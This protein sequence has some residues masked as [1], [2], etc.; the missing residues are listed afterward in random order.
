M[1]VK[2]LSKA[3][4]KQLYSLCMRESGKMR[5][6]LRTMPDAEVYMITNDEGQVYCWSIIFPQNDKHKLYI[7]T[8][9]RERRRGYAT[10]LIEIIRR[11][12]PD[13]I[14]IACEPNE[15]RLEF[16]KSVGLTDK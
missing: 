8:R 7:Y 4:F 16:F 1:K 15:D 13:V 2:D 10:A 3:R 9:A 12:Y 11:D 5:D 6:V 14:R